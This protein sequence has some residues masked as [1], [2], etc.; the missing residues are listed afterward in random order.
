MGKLEESILD[1]PKTNA[2]SGKTYAVP[3]M[4]SLLLLSIG[5]ILRVMHW[6][7]GSLVLFTGSFSLIVFCLI[8]FFSKKKRGLLESLVLVCVISFVIGFL[9]KLMYWPYHNFIFLFALLAFSGV[10]GIVTFNLIR[11][12]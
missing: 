3:I 10:F 12:K 8:R 9:F 6:P 7:Y 5:M 1:F 11:Q 4:V 2:T